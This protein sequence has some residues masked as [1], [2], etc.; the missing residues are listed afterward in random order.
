MGISNELNPSPIHADLP[1][2]IKLSF[3]LL[4][5]IADDRRNLGCVRK[6]KTLPIFSAECTIGIVRGLT[7]L[8]HYGTMA[9]RCNL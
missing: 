9:I 7:A 6:I 8:W 3:Y 4:E 5:I 1:E 2:G